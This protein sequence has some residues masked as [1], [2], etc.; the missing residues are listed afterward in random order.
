MGILLLPADDA[1]GV[2]VTLS[3]LLA[4]LGGCCQRCDQ[5]TPKQLRVGWEG[6]GDIGAHCVDK[7]LAALGLPPADPL[8]AFLEVEDGIA[9]RE[10]AD[11]FVVLAIPT[12]ESASSCRTRA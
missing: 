8:V 9:E 3:E 7:A 5:L 2:A 10:S 4:N 11:Q 6:T 12:Q 1:R